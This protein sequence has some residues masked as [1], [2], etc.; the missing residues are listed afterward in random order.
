MAI[1]YTVDSLDGVPEA[2]HSLYAESNGKFV[3]QVDGAVPKTRVDE[4]RN[5]N[6]ALK[7]QL[8]E[9]NV[10]FD[11]V[12]PEVFRELSS[13]ATKLR[14]KK[15]VD[16]G[17]FD[18][19]MAARVE[20]MKADHDAKY[21]ALKT[22]RDA[23]KS[24][25]ESLLIDG[26]LRDAA[27]KASVRATAI[28]DVLLR[29]R[30]TFRLAD[31]KAT[32]FDGDKALYGKDSEPLAVSDWVVGLA[33]RAPHLFEPSNGGNAPKGGS[34]SA[35]GKNTIKRSAWDA[36]G[37]AEKMAAAKTMTITD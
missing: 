5:N 37:P 11:G 18:E 14:D 35:G 13:Q 16:S 30:Q 15:L 26:A 32:A 23:T 36:L 31:G 9:M 1:A 28:D 4:F 29:G 27:M 21:G 12:D 3:L 20:A 10:R 2:M 25:L 7:R 19:L 6:L 33:E 8:D 17:K 34:Q 24:Q 22:E